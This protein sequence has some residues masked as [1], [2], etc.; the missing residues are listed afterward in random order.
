[1]NYCS[2][3]GQNRR[4]QLVERDVER[5]GQAAERAL[6]VCLMMSGAAAARRCIF[7]FFTVRDPF[8][9][10]HLVTFAILIAICQVVHTF[11]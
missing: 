7:G 2:G 3:V 4:Y 1:M 9:G 11:G 8:S 5:A 6:W 10:R